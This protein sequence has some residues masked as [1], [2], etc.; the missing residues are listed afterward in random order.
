V[1]TLLAQ[2]DRSQ[3]QTSFS[4]FSTKIR[5]QKMSAPISSNGNGQTNGQNAST[6]TK[7]SNGVPQEQ[8]HNTN[9]SDAP[10]GHHAIKRPNKIGSGLKDRVHQITKGPPGGFDPTPLPDAP[11]G[12][13]IRFI[14][15]GASN[16]APA[17][18]VTISSDPFLHA[19]LKGTQPKRHK[20]D[21]DLYHRTRTI[22]NS[23]EPQWD[24]EWVVANVPPTGF[25]LKCRLYD[26]DYPDHDDRLGNV[27]IKVPSI[28]QDW[29][30]IPPPGRVYEA[31]KRVMSKRAYLTKAVTSV[32]NHNMHMTPLLRVSM[33]LLGPSDPP[34]AQMY[35]VG[36]T[37]WVK[38]FSALI[39]RIAGVK[40]NA[41]SDDDARTDQDEQ[42]DQ[43]GNKKSKTQKYE[44]V[45]PILKLGSTYIFLV[46]KRMKCSLKARCHPSCTTALSSSDL[47]LH[48]SIL[49]RACAARF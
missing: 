7:E 39:G 43:A 22:R 19:T 1:K 10:H 32:V 30:G 45:H 6:A 36:P 11:Q 21:P 5:V 38:H 18:L 47:S 14:F 31:K 28:S 16:L 8:K 49:R 34:Y 3:A 26:E 44:Y 12:Y 13:T 17:D 48:Q 4:Y 46:S 15:H 2:T 42:V 9:G 27:T 35:T 40:V 33:E 29:K 24:D 25:T 37:T 20:E 41:N 23:T